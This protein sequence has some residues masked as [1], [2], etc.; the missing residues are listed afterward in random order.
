MSPIRFAARQQDQF[1][2]KRTAEEYYQENDYDEDIEDLED[3]DD[4]L[5]LDGHKIT[6]PRPSASSS[7]HLLPKLSL[8]S[9]LPN[10]EKD[11][12]LDPASYTLISFSTGLIL[13]DRICLD[14]YNLQPH[15]LLEL[16]KQPY[17]IKLP[18]HDEVAYVRPYFEAKVCALK[19]AIK[20]VDGERGD[21]ESRHGHD[22][23]HGAR[24]K[25][26]KK[27]RF[28]LGW[29][30]RWLVVHKGLIKL[31]RHRNVSIS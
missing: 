29:S 14:S 2:P 8:P 26:S 4:V 21:T 3:V 17:I 6:A 18:R 23:S 24:D 27:R 7:A 11:P 20:Q 30:D 5:S 22:S 1:K 13:E 10:Q 28:K 12:A 16:H 31:T 15:E 25:L 9:E 19:S